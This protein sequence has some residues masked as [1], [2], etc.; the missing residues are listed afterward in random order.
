MM[1]VPAF[2]KVSADGGA[3]PQSASA[4][5]GVYDPRTNLIWGRALVIGEFTWS[6]AI[7]AAA[8]ETLCGAVAGAPTIQERLTINDYTRHSPALDPVFFAKEI[9][10][11]WTSTLVAQSQS[12]SAFAWFVA[13]G[14]G[15]AGWNLQDLRGHVRAVR[16]GQ[17]FG[18]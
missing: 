16:S 8:K 4:W 6:D 5:D 12:P 1:E 15:Y 3:L 7:A 2:I 10:W 9:G 14:D 17:P 18:L 11:E 13:L